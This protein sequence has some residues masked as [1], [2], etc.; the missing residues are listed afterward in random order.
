MAAEKPTTYSEI[1]GRVIRMRRELAG[2]S[3]AEMAAAAGF[4]SPSGWSRLETGDVPLTIGKLR[5]AARRLGLTPTTILEAAD[6]L[7]KELH[8]VDD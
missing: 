5:L 4:S 2:I 6:D 3:I 7:A 1:V 8:A